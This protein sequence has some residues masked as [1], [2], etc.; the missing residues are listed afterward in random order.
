MLMMDVCCSMISWFKE[1]NQFMQ[2]QAFSH[3][4]NSLNYD[5]K[6]DSR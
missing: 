2:Q 4:G 1:H 6:S 5:R 3:D